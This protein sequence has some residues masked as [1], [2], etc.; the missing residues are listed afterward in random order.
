MEAKEEANI[1]IKE[2]EELKKERETKFELSNNPEVV[3]EVATI[4]KGVQDLEES[5][6]LM[7]AYLKGMLDKELK[8]GERIDKDI[9]DFWKE[10]NNVL[11][12][13]KPKEVHIKSES[14]NLHDIHMIMRGKVEDENN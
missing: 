7:R 14:I 10:Y 13:L 11:G 3:K 12:R 8:I 9:L 4:K 2:I 6:M 5:A 1:A